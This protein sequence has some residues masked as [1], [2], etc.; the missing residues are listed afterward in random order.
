MGVTRLEW[1]GIGSNWRRPVEI[2]MEDGSREGGKGALGVLTRNT[3]TSS[4]NTRDF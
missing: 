4:A 3:V 1:A 2:G